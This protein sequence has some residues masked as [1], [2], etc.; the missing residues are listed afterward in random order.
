MYP[1]FLFLH[2]YTVSYNEIIY[3]VSM[4]FSIYV[5]IYIHIHTHVYTY[6]WQQ[7][8]EGLA[9]SICQENS[10]KVYFK[11]GNLK[12]FTC[13]ITLWSIYIPEFFHKSIWSLNWPRDCTLKQTKKTP[14]KWKVILTSNSFISITKLHYLEGIKNILISVLGLGFLKVTYSSEQRLLK[15]NKTLPLKQHINIYYYMV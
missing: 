10:F 2:K 3:N 15:R 14:N 5:H 4:Y 12:H 13:F 7:N 1:D 9:G 8:T 6:V 11:K